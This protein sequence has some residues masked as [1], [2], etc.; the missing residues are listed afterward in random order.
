M[1]FWKKVKLFIYLS[2]KFLVSLIPDIFIGTKVRRIF[3]KLFFKKCGKNLI[4]YPL[5]H[6]EVSENIE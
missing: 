5:V 3:Y 2:L 4:V 1:K 6:I